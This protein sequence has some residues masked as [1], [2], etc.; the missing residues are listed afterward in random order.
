MRP[1]ILLIALLISLPAVAADEQQP[2]QPADQQPAAPSPY[3][4]LNKQVQEKLRAE[5]LYSGPISGE[6]GFNTQAAL[7]QFQLSRALPA[8]G[9]LDDTTLAAMGLEQFAEAPAQAAAASA[10][11]EQQAGGKRRCDDL[12][13]QEKEHCVQ[14]GGT[15]ETSVQSGSGASAP[16]R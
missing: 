4:E 3:L 15:I 7:A 8:S 2:S 14:Q 10:G 5:G 12:M 6:F 16:T 1:R 11:V 13:G 9:S